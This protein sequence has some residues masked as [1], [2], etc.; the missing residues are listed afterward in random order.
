MRFRKILFWLHLATGLLAGVVI[1]IMSF[2]GAILAFENEL[3]AWAERDA[4]RVETAS[5]ASARPLDELLAAAQA[6]APEGAKPS[7]LTLSR[8]PHDS[9]AINFTRDA[10]VYYVNPYTAEVIRP[11]STAMRDFMKKVVELHRYL[12]QS[13]DQRPLGKALTGAANLGFLFLALSGLYLWWPRAWSNL[14][15]LRPSLWYVKGARGRARDWNWHNVTGFWFLPILVVITLSAAVI[16]YRWASDLVYHV[17]GEKPQRGSYLVV[18]PAEVA[19]PSPN[20][21]RLGLTETLAQVQTRH[22]DWSQITLR[23]GYAQRPENASGPDPYTATLKLIDDDA[24]SFAPAQLVLDPYT[25]ATLSRTDYAEQSPGRK[26]RIWL[27]YLHTGQALGWPG[28]VLAGLASL[29]G[30]LLVYTGFALTYRRLRPAPYPAT[31][32]LP[33]QSNLLGYFACRSR[34]LPHRAL[35]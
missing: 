28:Q 25:G 6:V 32:P 29:A 10:G 14:Q 24:P 22:T 5:T 3:V 21:P 19:P 26:I 33:P 34:R 27:R 16:G 12:A 2:T 15:A 23:E 9:L 20:L 11:A 8:D 18:A 7:G 17:V 13:G 4:R 1:F 31:P 30:C 35:R